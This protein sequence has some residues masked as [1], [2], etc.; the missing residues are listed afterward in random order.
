MELGRSRALVEYPLDYWLVSTAGLPVADLVNLR[1]ETHQLQQVLGTL[2]DR[3]RRRGS[4]DVRWLQ[5][6]D[7]VKRLLA[8]LTNT[9]YQLELH[10]QD[11]LPDMRLLQLNP[12]MRQQIVEIKDR[13]QVSGGKEVATQKF[14]L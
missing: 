6:G 3:Y 1:T 8:E 12:Q 2:S 7:A 9:L 10:L 5:L 4:A 13:M 11:V 14:I